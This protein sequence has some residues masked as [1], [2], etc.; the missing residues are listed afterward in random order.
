MPTCP[1]YGATSFP[2]SFFLTLSLHFIH[3]FYLSL[4]HIRSHSNSVSS[5]TLVKISRH[6]LLVTSVASMARTQTRKRIL[7]SHRR[8]R[9]RDVVASLSLFLK[10]LSQRLVSSWLYISSWYEFATLKC[11]S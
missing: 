9:E 7:L 4:V 5:S 8:E 11:Q 1:V 6:T 2:L 10:S 3:T